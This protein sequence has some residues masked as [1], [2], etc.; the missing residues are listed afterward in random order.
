MIWVYLMISTKIL[1]P[2]RP[3][4]ETNFFSTQ[5]AT[6]FVS[7]DTFPPPH[8]YPNIYGSDDRLKLNFEF[9][10]EVR[11]LVQII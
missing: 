9:S 8:R 2:M 1:L 10:L 3:Y 6:Y 4:S 7:I 5:I 11:K